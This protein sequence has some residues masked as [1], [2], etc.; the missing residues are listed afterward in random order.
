MPE[1]FRGISKNPHD[2]YKRLAGEVEA[3]MVQNRMNLT[4]E[5]RRNAYPFAIG[6]YGYED[7]PKNEQ[8]ITFGNNKAMSQ[9]PLTEFEQA[10]LLA[11]QRA[12][13]PVN[14]RGLGFTC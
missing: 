14:Q 8:I 7:I 2:A 12:A 13:L 9:R 6:R 10:H 3:R 5:Q 4:P 11:Q 1:Q